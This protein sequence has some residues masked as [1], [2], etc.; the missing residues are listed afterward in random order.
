MPYEEGGCQADRRFTTPEADTYRL[1]VLTSGDD[2]TRAYVNVGYAAKGL[3]LARRP[4]TLGPIID[5]WGRYPLAEADIAPAVAS[6]RTTC[7][8]VTRSSYVTQWVVKMPTGGSSDPKRS[9]RR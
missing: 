6:Y 4:E 9:S 7:S 5:A 3:A 2:S 8:R 1:S